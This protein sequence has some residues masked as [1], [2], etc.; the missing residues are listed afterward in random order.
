MGIL[1]GTLINSGAIIAGGAAG[2]FLKKMMSARV[3]RS[4]NLALGYC[5]LMIGIKM[6]MLYQNVIVVVASVAAGAITG[7]AFDFHAKVQNLIHQISTKYGEG[8]GAFARGFSIASVIYC[9]GSMSIVGSIQSGLQENHEILIAKAILDGV[10]AIGF[11][12]I[13]GAGAIAAFLPVLLYQ[14]GLTLLSSQLTFLS[15]EVILNDITG[16]GGILVMMIGLNLS[17]IKKVE[18]EN[19]LPSMIFVIIFAAINFLYFS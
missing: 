13:Y 17:E 12:A 7:H 15:S 3:S 2:F 1:T 10:I 9:V 14:G 11:S 4:I 19:F 6:C 18:L 5:V 16:V 8:H